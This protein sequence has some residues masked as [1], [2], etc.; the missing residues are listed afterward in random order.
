MLI[1]K[2]NILFVS[3]CLGL[4]IFVEKRKNCKDNFKENKVNIFMCVFMV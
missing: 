1:L 3:F 2:L 4:F